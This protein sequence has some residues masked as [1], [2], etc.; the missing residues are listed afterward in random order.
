MLIKFGLHNELVSVMLTVSLDVDIVMR[1]TEASKGILGTLSFS[2]SVP[3]WSGKFIKFC[4]DPG[5]S[6]RS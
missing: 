6:Y 4:S 2:P 1:W 5:V 3:V